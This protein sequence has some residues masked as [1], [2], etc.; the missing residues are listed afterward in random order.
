MWNGILRPIFNFFPTKRFIF[1]V[2]LVRTSVF[3]DE[4]GIESYWER[5]FRYVKRLLF[6]IFL[7]KKKIK[8]SEYNIF[9]TNRNLDILC[10]FWE[11]RHPP[12]TKITKEKNSAQFLKF[13]GSLRFLKNSPKKQN[14]DKNILIVQ[15]NHFESFWKRTFK[16]AKSWQLL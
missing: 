9:Y 6:F 15:S 8:I 13:Y 3:L 14:F 10:L 12:E 1:F 7:K 2:S 11:N 4:V 5:I 16:Y